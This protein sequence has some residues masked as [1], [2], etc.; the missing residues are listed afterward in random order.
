MTGSVDD[1]T[2]PLSLGHPG[3]VH[4]DISGQIALILLT[5]MIVKLFAVLL[6][7]GLNWLGTRHSS[8][9]GHEWLQPAEHSTAFPQRGEVPPDLDLMSIAGGAVTAV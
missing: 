9:S 3:V 1:R 2:V 4:Q 7:A 8:L 6:H 5:V